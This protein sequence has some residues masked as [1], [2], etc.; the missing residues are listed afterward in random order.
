[1]QSS[2]YAFDLKLNSSY[3]YDNNIYRTSANKVTD[4]LLKLGVSAGQDISKYGHTI[5]ARYGLNLSRYVEKTTEDTTDYSISLGYSSNPVFDYIVTGNVSHTKSQDKRGSLEALTDNNNLPDTWNS[6]GY[7]LG[8]SYNIYKYKVVTS[9]DYSATYKRYDLEL[10]K[11]KNSDNYSY[12]WKT[13]YIYSGKT[14]LFISVGKGSNHYVKPGQEIYDSN[15]IAYSIGMDWETSGKVSSTFSIGWSESTQ[16]ISKA[17]AYSGIIFNSV[18]N[19]KRKSF[20]S[21][22]L[23]LSRSVRENIVNKQQY[24]VSNIMRINS[25]RKLAYRVVANIKS[26]FVINEPQIGNAESSIDIS[27]EISYRIAR[28]FSVKTGITT[29][30]KTSVDNQ[31]SYDALQY[32]FSMSYAL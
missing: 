22:S 5:M 29:L 17:S 19:W 32:K 12:G 24:Y 27:P 6:K 10:S 13:E 25:I 3:L 14:S 7:K 18:I 1:M 31:N 15:S 16:K 28:R 9:L 26:S 30:I 8:V 11:I 4:S 21:Y 2:S 23:S 20:N